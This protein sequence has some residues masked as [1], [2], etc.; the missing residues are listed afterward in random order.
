MANILEDVIP[1]ILAGAAESLRETCILPR[2]VNG[3]YSQDAAAK[4][5]VVEIPIPTAIAAHQ[6][7]MP[8]ILVI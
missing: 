1:K 5:S 8:P 3:D 2:L 6:Q 4:G 7:L